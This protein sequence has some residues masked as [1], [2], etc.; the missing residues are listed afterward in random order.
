MLTVDVLIIGGGPAGS[1]LGYSLQKAGLICCIVDK[2]AFPRKK[3]CGGLLTQKTADLI[4]DIFGDVSFPCEYTTKNIRLFL[5]NENLS[6][7]QTDSNFYLVNRVDFDF[8]FIRQYLGVG[9]ILF[10]NTTVK[11]VNLETNS[12]MLSSREEIHYKVLVGAD[13]ANSQVRKYIDSKYRPNA[14][15]LEFDSPANEIGDEIQVY[16]STLR[17]GYGWCFPKKG[18]YT[19]GIGGEI[20]VNQD[21]KK[22]FKLFYR[23]INKTAGSENI[24]GALIPF[25]RYVKVPC[26]G[27]ILLVGDAAGLVDPITGEGIYFAFLS[28]MYASEAI[29]KFLVSNE[30]FVK[31]YLLD[32][33][34]IQAIITGA[35][36]FNRLLFNEAVKPLFLKMVKDKT[37]IIKYFCENLLSRYNMTYLGFVTKYIKTR[38][39]RKKAEKRI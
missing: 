17:S 30:Y 9:G 26:K 3:L 10:D 7:V 29:Q 34:H 32:I 6:R 24:T 33:K 2:A 39:E 4:E 16:F 22:S 35:N 1:S 5:G 14:M 13:G 37:H 23:S 21:I 20:K 27:N 18:Y 25:G 38:H 11:K 36:R 12:A 8:Y 19:V 31:T 28:A 15:C